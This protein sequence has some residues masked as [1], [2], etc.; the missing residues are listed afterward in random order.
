MPFTLGHLVLS[1]RLF[2]V[3]VVQSIKHRNNSNIIVGE[4]NLS[5]LVPGSILSRSHSSFYPFEHTRRVFLLLRSIDSPG[6][7]K[8]TESVRMKSG[9]AHDYHYLHKL[10]R[11]GGHYHVPPF[12]FLLLFRFQSATCSPRRGYDPRNWRQLSS[13]LLIVGVIVVTAKEGH[14]LLDHLV[15]LTLLHPTHMFAVFFFLFIPVHR[16]VFKVNANNVRRS[17]I[18]AANDR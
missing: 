3:A 16:S 10:R 18:S 7:L 9:R 11:G 8:A 6:R 2:H 1:S 13:G 12:A 4:Q 17:S 5:S 15:Q 14:R